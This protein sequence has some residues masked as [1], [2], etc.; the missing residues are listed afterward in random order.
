LDGGVN[1]IS[2]DHSDIDLILN[3][4]SLHINL[5]L[6]CGTVFDQLDWFLN[7]W[8]DRIIKAKSAK[9]SHVTANFIFKFFSFDV[10]VLFHDIIEVF[11][12]HLSKS[13][14]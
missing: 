8:A 10:F 9:V 7:S 13:I 4:F 5:V 14:G 6:N 12:G 11:F 1:V 3:T 2:C